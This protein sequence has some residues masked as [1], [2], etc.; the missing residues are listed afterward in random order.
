M[1]ARTLQINTEPAMPAALRI[2]TRSDL[3]ALKGIRY[4]RQRMNELIRAKLFPPPDG[5]ATD[6]PNS[7]P[8]WWESTIDKHLKKRAAKFAEETAKKA[9]TKEAA[10]S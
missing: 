7:P 9:A 1:I 10:T 6:N 3:H 8:W 2:L 4:S 5:R